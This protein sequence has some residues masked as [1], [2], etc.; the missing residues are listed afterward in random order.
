MAQQRNIQSAAAINQS[1]AEDRKIKAAV[2]N[3]MRFLLNFVVQEGESFEF[4]TKNA[5][6]LRM[7]LT[8]LTKKKLK[9][10]QKFK[11]RREPEVKQIK[12]EKKQSKQGKK[13]KRR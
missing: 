5:N 11:K 3:T 9:Q 13:Q 6:G 8:E 10:V 12:P 4:F 2:N 7:A 1:T